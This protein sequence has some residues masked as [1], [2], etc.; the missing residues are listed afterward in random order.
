MPT[1]DPC[2]YVNISFSPFPLEDHY[3]TVSDTNTMIN[4]I[5]VSYNSTSPYSFYS[6]PFIKF[7]VSEY[8]FCQMNQDTGKNPDHSDYILLNKVRGCASKG[9]WTLL[10]S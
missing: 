9:N 8:E 6:Y 2:P 1:T 10:G 7:A 3:L 4:P 5:Y